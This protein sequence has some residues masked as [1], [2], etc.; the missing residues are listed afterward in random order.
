MGLFEYIVSMSIRACVLVPLAVVVRALLTKYPKR[1]SYALWLIVFAGIIV[2]ISLPVAEIN[3]AAQ[4][5][6]SIQ[7]QYNE[8]LDDYVADVVI[9]HD[10]TEEYAQAIEQ[11]IQPIISEEAKYVITAADSIAPPK[12]VKTSVM[13]KIQ[14]V[15]I[16]GVLALL[17]VYIRNV[18]NMLGTI[19]F[20]T[21]YKYDI[22]YS[23]NIASPFVFGIIKPKIYLPYNIT[24]QQAEH[25]IAHERVHIKR[26]DYIVKPL[27]LFIT[28]L[29]WFN[30]M[31][32]LAFWLMNKDMEF[33]CDEAAVDTFNTDSKKD[34]C[35]AL[36]QFALKDESYRM[37]T[38]MFGESDCSR[39][40]KNL[41]AS[42]RPYKLVAEMLVLVVLA[43]AIGCTA[44]EKEAEEFVPDYDVTVEDNL[45]EYT[46]DGIPIDEIKQHPG[47]IAVVPQEEQKTYYYTAVTSDYFT[48]SLFIGDSFADGFRVYDTIDNAV[49]DKSDFITYNNMT[50][51]NFISELDDLEHRTGLEK[52][53][54]FDPY[55]VYIMMGTDALV[56][57]SDAKFISEYESM[58]GAVKAKM[59]EAK[60]YVCSV[61]P[62]SAEQAEK[63]TAFEKENLAEIN[64]C[65]AQIAEDNGAYYLNLHEILADESGYLSKDYD[66]F[67]G[68]H[69]YS[70]KY[71]NIIDYLRT[72]VAVEAEDLEDKSFT[73]FMMN[74]TSAKQ[75]FVGGTASEK[76]LVW[77]T[78]EDVRIT[79]GFAGAYPAH[80]GLDIAGPLDTE[81][82]AAADGTVDVSSE[83]TTFYG[84]YIIINH[85]NGLRTLYAHCNNLLVKEGET[86]T[87]GELIATMGATGNST[88]VHLHFGVSQDYIYVNPLEYL[89]LILEECK[90]CTNKVVVTMM[91]FS[92]WEPTD[93]TN[94]AHNF[95]WGYDLQFQRTYTS[96]YACQNCGHTETVNCTEVKTE[97]HG[98]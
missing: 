59:P 60:I 61:P 63:R 72:H 82:Y 87:K 10:N 39:R 1:Y 81:I 92:E 8:V 98:F 33:S 57:I 38:V 44:E 88:G 70:R 84:N 28:I 29:H 86:V 51:Q 66:L 7:Q 22:Y 62:V 97:C 24:A 93:S 19:R 27:C 2:K 67:D 69:I 9:H 40:I 30:P 15:W 68:I 32:W 37:S 6:H 53:A 3:P 48:E 4:V 55:S 91:D 46:E 36:V 65:I 42:K 26:L 71:S 79:R 75:H 74:I 17:V 13:P 47:H 54:S 20:A 45:S 85:G 21:H 25:V 94:C 5:Q 31:V 11:G 50:P 18:L 78:E 83:G 14:I 56:F 58:I 64:G 73:R 89:T 96:T 76:G 80:D 49:A 34:Y 95:M 77:P 16:V 41:L 52:A 23:E 35:T 12:T 90:Q 43:T